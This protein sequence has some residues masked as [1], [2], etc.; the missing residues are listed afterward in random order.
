MAS[1]AVAV[2]ERRMSLARVFERGFSAIGGNWKTMFAIAFLFSALPG[3]V[4]GYAS[5]YIQAG[6]IANVEQGGQDPGASAIVV[7]LITLATVLFAIILAVVTQGALVRA[8]IAH[9]EGRKAGFGESALA[10]LSMALPLLGLS[11]LLALAVMLGLFLLIVPGVMLYIIWSV[12]SP[13]L[14]AERSGVFAAF[15][16]SRFLTKGA[17][18]KIFALQLVIIVFYWMVSG[19]MGVLLLASYGLE[20]LETASTFFPW[21]YMVLNV[22]LQT[23]IA[24]IWGA[25]QTSL[26]VELRDWKDGPDANALADIFA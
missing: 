8:T 3:G 17:R 9:T 23:V 4:I 1:S 7:G 26:Y 14:V 5:Q 10:G 18:W 15:G 21:W 25:I 19:A 2:E 12:A 24:A 6:A 13:A 11:L 20:G 22:I 16:R